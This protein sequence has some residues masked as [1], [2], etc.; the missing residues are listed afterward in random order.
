MSKTF[1]YL[2]EVCA[3]VT[4]GTH[5]TPKDIGNGVPFLTVKDVSERGL[6][7]VNCS[8][9]SE[10]D[11][12]L[13]MNGN[14]VPLAGDILF[15]KDGTVGK[16]HV[17]ETSQRFAVLSSLAILRPDTTKIDSKYLGHALKSPSILAQAIKKK[18]GSAIRRIVL[19]DLKQL[20]IPL[21]H[22]DEQRR[23]AAILDN[24]EGLRAKR[25]AA[26]ALLDLI[27]Q[28]IFL[29]MFGDPVT[30]RKAWRTGILSE[31][32]IQI[33]DGEHQT[34]KRQS[35]GIKL[36]SARNV[37]DGF[38]DFS[39]VDHVGDDEYA[40]ISKRCNP[41]PGDVLI[42]CSGTI[43]RVAPV[44][45]D[46]PLSLVRSA[47]LV[48]PKSDVITTN[49]L[50]ELLRT[51]SLRRRMVQRANASSQ[52]NLFQNQIR[53]LPVIFP[54]LD[55]QNDFAALVAAIRRAKTY[56]KTALAEVEAL[57]ASLQSQLLELR[58]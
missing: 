31:A 25:R 1:A 53:E 3:L 9:I 44:I 52:A 48:K 54:P 5:Y 55:F 47:A 16:V 45:V 38:L 21:P 10:H 29:E 13:A 40:R 18:T 35:T 49:F 2:S 7:F 12:D 41:R 8:H 30:N 39:D 27:P 6:D 50:V 32:S 19:S 20:Q 37:K 22:L 11:F 46:E 36:L 14:C 34:P 51:P 26:L 24:A 58:K 28:A 43:G 56:H 17:V 4:D 15:S 42:S 23:I 33:T 57:F